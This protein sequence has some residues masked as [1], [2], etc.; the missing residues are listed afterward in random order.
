M[1]GGTFQSF[2]C[3]EE[4]EAR[5]LLRAEVENWTWMSRE[6]KEEIISS[7]AFS[8]TE[9]RFGPMFDTTIPVD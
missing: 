9:T 8:R 6:R 1:T 5:E 4:N 7:A 3:D 2:A